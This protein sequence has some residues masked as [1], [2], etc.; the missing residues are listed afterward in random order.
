VGFV[1]KRPNSQEQNVAINGSATM[2]INM[3]YSL[4]ITIV[5]IEITEDILYVVTT[6]QK[7]IRELG[8]SVQNVEKT[9]KQKFMFITVQMTTT[10]KR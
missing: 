6:M 2:K 4:M 5:A 1:G 10:L 9:L 7:H 8:K 3:F